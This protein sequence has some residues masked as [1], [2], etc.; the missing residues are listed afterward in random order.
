MSK[1]N[2]D[3][4][5][6]E[7]FRAARKEKGTG[8]TFTWKGKSYS[9][10][11]KEEGMPG[12]KKQGAKSSDKP[13]VRSVM[14]PFGDTDTSKD[15]LIS[16]MATGLSSKK[17]DAPKE[18]D[19]RPAGG[20]LNEKPSGVQARGK[21]RSGI[22]EAVVEALRPRSIGSPRGAPATRKYAKGGAVRGDGC[23]SKGKTK[24]KF[25]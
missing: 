16:R 8:G 13:A 22:D 3:M 17:V 19:V 4:S 7:A 14:K 2:D 18:T 1:Q 23:A 11:T 9:T 21:V 15:D 24:G 12:S 5:F 10:N 25:R 6:G 20:L